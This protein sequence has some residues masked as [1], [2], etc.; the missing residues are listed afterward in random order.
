MQLDF[1]YSFSFCLSLSED[2]VTVGMCVF[3]ILCLVSAFRV[4]FALE[5]ATKAQR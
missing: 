1:M 4:N 5:Q 2:T 3:R